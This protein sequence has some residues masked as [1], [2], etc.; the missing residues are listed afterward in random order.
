MS[1]L[2][3][4]QEKRNLE[5]YQRYKITLALKGKMTPSTESVIRLLNTR[6]KDDERC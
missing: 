3:E 5:D 4:E 1:W 2:E 6:R